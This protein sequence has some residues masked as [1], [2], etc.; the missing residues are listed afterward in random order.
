MTHHWSMVFLQ[1]HW[2]SLFPFSAMWNS[3][4]QWRLWDAINPG[5]LQSS[6]EICLNKYDLKSYPILRANFVHVRIPSCIWRHE[7]YFLHLKRD[8]TMLNIKCMMSRNFIYIM[9]KWNR[10]AQHHSGLC[11]LLYGETMPSA[12]PILAH[13]CSEQPWEMRECLPMG[14]RADLLTSLL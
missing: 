12:F 7:F 10:Q 6:T 4:D 8:K 1:G 11:H 13:F 2:A 9:V 3:K 5:T 14:Q